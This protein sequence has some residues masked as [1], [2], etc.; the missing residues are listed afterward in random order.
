LPTLPYTPLSRPRDA[1]TVRHVSRQK[2]QRPR[3]A[4]PGPPATEPFEQPLEDVEGLVGPSVDVWR[5]RVSCRAS[6]VQDTKPAAGVVALDLADGQGVEEP[7]RLALVRS[8]DQAVPGWGLG[9]AHCI[10]PSLF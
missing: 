4:L 6:L 3:T 5:W 2:H 8:Q 9:S 10:V 7:E 1:E